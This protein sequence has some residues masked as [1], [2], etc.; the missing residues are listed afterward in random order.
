MNLDEET[1]EPMNMDEEMEELFWDDLMQ[2]L[3][4]TGVDPN[5]MDPE[6]QELFFKKAWRGIKK[7][8]KKVVGGVKKAT[9]VIG[10]GLN[11]FQQVSKQAMPFLPENIRQMA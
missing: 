9:G 2:N 4:S 6:M 11:I 10:K 8:G 3:V 5:E 1:F 7:V